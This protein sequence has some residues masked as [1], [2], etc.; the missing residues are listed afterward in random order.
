MRPLQSR[1]PKS[2]LIHLE[3]TVWR[4]IATSIALSSPSSA[5]M[6][7]AVSAQI[8]HAFGRAN[9]PLLRLR[10]PSFLRICLLAHRN[11]CVAQLTLRRVGVH[12]RMPHCGN[13]DLGH[14]YGNLEATDTQR[15]RMIFDQSV[16]QA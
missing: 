1:R 6:S 3:L 2:A 15:G 10:F 12:S 5:L 16:A 14:A 11:D 9:A 13:E 4:F 7:R 8:L